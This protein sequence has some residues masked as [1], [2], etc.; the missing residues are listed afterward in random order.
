MKKI[1]NIISEYG[2]N[3]TEIPSD[4]RTQGKGRENQK[5]KSGRNGGKEQWGLC[6]PPS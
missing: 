6:V 3:K 1:Q 2:G 4:D 5:V